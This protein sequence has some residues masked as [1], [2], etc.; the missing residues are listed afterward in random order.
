MA[1]RTFVDA[2]GTEWQVYDVVPLAA[3]RR[4]YDR[5]SPH[6]QP[7]VERRE[8]D[9]RRL[10]VGRQSLLA[11]SGLGWLCF[12]AAGQ[13]KRLAPIPENWSQATEPELERYCGLARAVRRV[14]TPQR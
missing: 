13:R 3:E 8:G 7:E 6:E 11:G 5:R 10:T 4:H 14:P 2:L 9:D 12:E 1:M